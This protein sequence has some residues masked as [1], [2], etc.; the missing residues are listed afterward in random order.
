VYCALPY[1]GIRLSATVSGILALSLN[2]AAYVSE[3]FRAGILSINKGQIEAA[4]ALGLNTVQTMR[5]VILPQA[6]K[7][8]IPPL[9]SNYVACAKDTAICSSISILEL[10]KQAMTFQAVVANP[11]PLIAATAIYIAF[12]V[13]LTRIAGILE[14]RMKT[15]IRRAAV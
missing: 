13:P 14:K 7:V 3:I 11:T 4:H 1:T 8:V 10:L 2:S 5:L 15:N 6:V 12:L 9:A